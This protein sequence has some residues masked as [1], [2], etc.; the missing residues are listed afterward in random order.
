MVLKKRKLRKAFCY[1]LSKASRENG[2]KSKRRKFWVKM[3]F[4]ER[5]K[6]CRYLHLKL[7][8][9]RVQIENKISGYVM[10]MDKLCIFEISSE[11]VTM[12]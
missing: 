7:Q 1:M 12:L 8:S 3:L 10:D 6:H 5:K 4:R 2:K 11:N 9:M